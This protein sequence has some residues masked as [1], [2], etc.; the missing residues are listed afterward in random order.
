MTGWVRI[1]RVLLIRV[2]G[3]GVPDT[4]WQPGRMIPAGHIPEPRGDEPG[5]VELIYEEVESC[6]NVSY[7]SRMDRG[8]ARLMLLCS[9]WHAVVMS[10]APKAQHQ[11]WT[12]PVIRS[13]P[14]KCSG[15]D[16]GCL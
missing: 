2:S 11:I 16:H 15:T 14:E 5:L 10:S 13:S 1:L 3:L 8:T 7:R 4:P 12:V 9:F 6:K